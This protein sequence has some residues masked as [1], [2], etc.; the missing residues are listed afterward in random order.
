MRSRVV[1]ILGIGLLAVSFGA[2]LARMLPEMPAISIAFWR[3]TMA[4]LLL[5]I[6]AVIMKDEQLI[7]LPNIL[8]I[9]AGIMLAAHFFTFYAALKYAGIAQ[10][11]LLIALSPVFALSIERIFMGRRF[12]T[13]LIIGLAL[14]LLGAVII[15]GLEFDMTESA[16][17]GS[18]IALCSALCWAAV[19]LLGERIRVNTDT[20]AYTRWMYSIAALSLGLVILLSSTSVRFELHELT[21]VLALG[22]IPTLIGHNSLHYAVK[23]LRPT[24]VASVTI[25]EPVLASLLAWILF[26]EFV[27]VR[28]VVGGLVVIVG[29][30]II[31]LRQRGADSATES[32]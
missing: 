4:S 16:S 5:W 19:L 29:L 6:T 11:T 21:W 9:P 2:P 14:A 18:I 23:F 20:A 28:T 32:G 24:I 10:V 25:G 1:I 17:K 7:S 15:Q 26:G 30:L 3:M 27:G 31:T 12:S 13:Q 8:I 22:V